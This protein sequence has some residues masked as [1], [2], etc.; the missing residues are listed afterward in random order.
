ME[1][2]VAP[3]AAGRARKDKSREG[4]QIGPGPNVPVRDDVCQSHDQTSGPRVTR[5]LPGGPSLLLL[6][7]GEDRFISGNQ[8]KPT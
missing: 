6:H 3:T 7:F 8:V 1:E 5:P 4:Q 2:R